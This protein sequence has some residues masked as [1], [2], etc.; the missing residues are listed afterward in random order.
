MVQQDGLARCGA[1]GSR[2]CDG[3]AHQRVDQRGFPGPRGAAHHG[4]QGRVE[5]A[6]AGQDVVVELSHCFPQLQPR[7]VRAGQ[8]ERQPDCREVLPYRVKE[9]GAGCG[10]GG[11]MGAHSIIMPVHGGV[12]GQS[13]T[14]PG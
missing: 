12:P 14:A 8:S 11:F 4:Q 6:V 9:R 13:K 1:D 10:L 5:A 7:L 3:A 2:P